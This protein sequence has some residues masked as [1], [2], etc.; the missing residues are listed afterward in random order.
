[1]NN[2]VTVNRHQTPPPPEQSI[3]KAL[4]YVLWLPEVGCSTMFYL[5]LKLKQNNEFLLHYSIS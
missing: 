2:N 4:S 3:L 5:Y 1:M